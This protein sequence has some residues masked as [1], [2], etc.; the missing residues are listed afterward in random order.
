MHLTQATFGLIF[1]V[2]LGSRR[3]QNLGNAW[4]MLGKWL[5]LESD[6]E[7]NGEM[8]YNMLVEMV[9]TDSGKMA[10]EWLTSRRKSSE[11]T[12]AELEKLGEL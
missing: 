3:Q 5:D 12:T 2:V 10:G 11:N 4:G 6:G 1:P 9:M 7:K 8:L